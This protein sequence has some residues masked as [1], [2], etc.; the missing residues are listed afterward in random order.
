MFSLKC[1]VKEKTDITKKKA[2][3]PEPKMIKHYTLEACLRKN[4]LQV[5]LSRERISWHWAQRCP[6]K[7]LGGGVLIVIPSH[8]KQIS[9]SR[10][11]GRACI[12]PPTSP[13]TDTDTHDWDDK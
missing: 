7:E 6:Q 11:L 12:S 5:D 1:S 4:N 3:Q 13:P 9:K 10:I 8:Q 2:S